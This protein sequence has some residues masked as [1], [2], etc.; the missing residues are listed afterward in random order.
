MNITLQI[1]AGNVEEANSL[2]ETVENIL[3]EKIPEIE[4]GLNME[5]IKKF[6]VDFVELGNLE[7]SPITGKV[8]KL[9]DKRVME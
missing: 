7:R 9:I 5:Y 1:E 4:V 2:K 8:K 3:K 6:S